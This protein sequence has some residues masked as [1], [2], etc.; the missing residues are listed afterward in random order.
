M[1]YNWQQKDWPNFKYD[2]ANLEALLYQF[3]VRQGH[4][5]GL[6]KA[7]PE[8]IQQQSLIDM[9]V[10]EALKTFEIEGEYLSR[11]DVLSSI[12]NNLGLNRI[13]EKI[14]DKRLRYK[15]YQ[16]RATEALNDFKNKLDSC[17]DKDH[18]L[19]KIY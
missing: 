15:A 7:L 14:K 18:L 19:S 13:P 5:S 1:Q 4:I 11:E 9:M 3:A 6:L 10:A 12:R 17:F 2:L 8:G 16:E